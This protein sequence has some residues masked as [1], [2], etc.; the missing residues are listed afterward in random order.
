MHIIMCGMCHTLY[1]LVIRSINALIFKAR[2]LGHDV[3][4]SNA[5]EV[6]KHIHVELIKLVLLF[7]LD[8]A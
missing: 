5:E 7:A 2:A 4:V 8:W 6:P 1:V 3:S